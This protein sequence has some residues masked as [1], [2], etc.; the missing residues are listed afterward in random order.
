DAVVRVNALALLKALV[1]AG[2]AEDRAG[3]EIDRHL[4]ESQE[5]YLLLDRLVQG[6]WSRQAKAEVLC[7]LAEASCDEQAKGWPDEGA[8]T[9]LRCTLLCY[10]DEAFA[11]LMDRFWSAEDIKSLWQD[12]WLLYA[13]RRTGPRFCRAAQVALR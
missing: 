12:R 2:R 9:L 5:A 1:A 4:H 7:E 6:P 11:M 10:P 13:L 3:G 8:G